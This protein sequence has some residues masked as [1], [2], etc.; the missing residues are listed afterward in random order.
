M[1]VVNQRIHVDDQGKRDIT[2]PLNKLAMYGGL[3]FEIETCRHED[4]EVRVTSTQ[5]YEVSDWAFAQICHKIHAP[6]EFMR[7]LDVDLSDSI[8][9][10]YMPQAVASG[11]AFLRVK[12]GPHPSDHTT[13]R[14]FLSDKYSM[15][16]NRVVLDMFIRGADFSCEVLDFHL[17]DQGFWLKVCMPTPNEFGDRIGIMIGN[18]EIG[19]RSAT[20]ECG[21]FNPEK[22]YNIV[23]REN[24]MSQRH[25]H[26][27]EYDLEMKMAK[28]IEDNIDLATQSIQAFVESRYMSTSSPI[29][30]LE[31][32][33]TRFGYGQDTTAKVREYFDRDS[34]NVVIG[35]NGNVHSIVKAFASAAQDYEGD[36]RVSMERN[37]GTLFS[38]RDRWS[39]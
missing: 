8:F 30:I 16:N 26:I 1:D 32:Y 17:N 36:R 27:D 29:V 24:V 31:K 18:S 5:P 35:H 4:E 11:L 21:I 2:V 37:A 10:R 28:S 20:V 7:R 3:M 6:V 22:R 23:L 33:C 9:N 34:G 12:D 13:L 39:D 15:L 14:A 19:A 38:W 25:V